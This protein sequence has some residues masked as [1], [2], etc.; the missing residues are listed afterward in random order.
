[1]ATD[2]LGTMVN[3]LGKFLDKARSRNIAVTIVLWNGATALPSDDNLKN[4]F[5]D[6][7]KLQS[8]IDNAL[9]P[10]VTAL[11]DKQAL[12]SWE[13]INEP[14][15]NVRNNE[16]HANPCH[17]TTRLAGSGAGWGGANI[18]MYNIQRFVNWQ[19]AAIKEADPKALVTVGSWNEKPQNDAYS[20][21]FNYYKDECLRAAGG[22]SSGIMDYYQMHTYAQKGQWQTNA[23]FAVKGDSYNLDKPL[24]IGEFSQVGSPAD[25][26]DIT[27]QFNHA[28]YEWYQ[29]A[30]SWQA[31]GGGHNADDFDTQ[32]R[33]TRHLQG[34]N[35]QTKG[36]RVNFVFE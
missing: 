13:I 23:P 2:D 31:N 7:D 6:E 26:N 15:G 35:D 34:R 5:L 18:P 11:S 19:M 1:M 33:G 9:V 4:L 30:W 21:S 28:Y 17:D 27:R 24:V 25:W 12:A 29:G 3:D 8:Y 16:T 32:A 20:D 36:G 22:R 14:E 10:M